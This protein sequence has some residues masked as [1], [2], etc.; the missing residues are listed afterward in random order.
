MKNQAD[1][2]RVILVLNSGSSSLKF[3]VLRMPGETRIC[4]GMVER[5]G[6]G[7][8]RL[9]FDSGKAKYERQLAVT[10]HKEALR[11]IVSALL[12]PDTGVLRDSKDVAAVGHRVVHGGTRFTGTT[13]VDAAVKEAI[14][15]LSRLAPLHNPANLEGIRQAES[16]F[17]EAIQVAVFDTAFHQTIPMKARRYAIPES[18]YREH[19]VQVYGFHGTSHKYIAEQLRPHL[20]EDGKL[21]CLH[22]GS[23][24]SATAIRGGVSLDHSLGFTPSNGLVMGSRSGD[25]DHGVIFYMVESLGYPLE[26]VKRILSRESG[27]KGLTGKSDLRDIEAV[28]ATGD[29]DCQLAL[30]MAAYRIRKYIGAYAAAM[31]GLD[32][33]AFTAG[34]GEHSSRMRELV[35]RDMEFLGIRLDADCNAAPGPGLQSIHAEDSRVKLWVVPTDE[36]LEIARQTYQVL[37]GSA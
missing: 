24:C 11:H 14:A 28:A 2:N 20:P 4:Q 29:P 35:C 12:D 37:T 18:L 7:D 13:R 1:M 30:E 17:H 27:L 26:E 15:D 6:A 34:I 5:I 36:E 19:G 3:Q 16:F 10:D 32:G 23:G 25:I 31:N 8:A 22:L 9:K 33:V 21:V